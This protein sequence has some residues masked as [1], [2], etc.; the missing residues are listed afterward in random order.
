MPAYW[1]GILYDDACLDAAWDLV[2]HWTAEERQKLRDDVPML[3][4]KAEIRGVTVRE[5]ASQ[6]LAVAREGLT[7]RG[8]KDRDGL[9]ETQYLAPL[10][11]PSNA[12]SRHGG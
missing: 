4:F 3:G 6:T 9:D 10:E 2:K 1:A 5:L 8:R 12:A 7:R 11:D